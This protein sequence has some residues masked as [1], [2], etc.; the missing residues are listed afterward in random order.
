VLLTIV[1]P[2]IYSWYLGLLAAYE[3]HIYTKKVKGIIFRKSWNTVAFGIVWIIIS[4]IMLQYFATV[5]AKL[6]DF[7]LQTVML[8]IYSLLPIIAVGYVLVAIGAKRLTKIE[9]V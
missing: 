8:L 3:L 9:V 7:S 4:S 6:N 2:Y 1:V 5:S